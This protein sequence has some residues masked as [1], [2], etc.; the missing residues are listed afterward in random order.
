MPARL[1]PTSPWIVLAAAVVEAAVGYPD[2][3]HRRAPHPV[4]WIGGL[5]S[6][7]EA[8][9]N[10]PGFGEIARRLLGVV[11]LA[12]IVGASALAGWIVA[13]LGG[14]VAIVLVGTVGLAQRSLF[15][16]VRAVAKPLA[17]GDLAVRASR[18]ATSS[19]ATSPD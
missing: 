16:H 9:L 15:D 12:L 18:S 14:P 4:V 11:T 3:L 19:A 2:A 7:L 1:L 17:A 5:I 10:L 8:G 6:A 13:D